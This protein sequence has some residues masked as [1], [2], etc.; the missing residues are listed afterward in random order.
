MLRVASSSFSLTYALSNRR[1][2]LARAFQARKLYT[3]EVVTLWYR[4]PEVGVIAI[5]VEWPCAFTSPDLLLCNHLS[6]M[7]CSCFSAT[8]STRPRLTCGPPAASWRSCFADSLCSL[9]IPR[10]TKFFAYSGC[11]AHLQRPPGRASRSCLT[12]RK[13]FPSGTRRQSMSKCHK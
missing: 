11:V 6:S 3:Q 9:A 7:F 12:I 13:I 5:P 4:A 8:L 1:S 10:S 2:G